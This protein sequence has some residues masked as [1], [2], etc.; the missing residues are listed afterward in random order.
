[1]SEIITDKLGRKIAIKKPSTLERIN[2]FR[3]LG[4]EDCGNPMVLAELSNAMWVQSIDDKPMPK[5]Q[6][7]DIEVIINELEKGDADELIS[8]HKIELFKKR[9]EA[10]QGDSE[11]IKK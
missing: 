11:L 1:M 8:R 3:I 10:E 2:F 5:K 4:A 6:M 9:Q 7:V